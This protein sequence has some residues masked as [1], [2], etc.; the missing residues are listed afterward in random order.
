[1]KRVLPIWSVA[2]VAAI[3]ACGAT[4][5]GMRF[6]LTPAPPTQ[7]T[8]PTRPSTP[9]VGVV[10]MISDASASLELAKD[11]NT[12]VLALVHDLQ[13]HHTRVEEL[14]KRLALDIA[15]S[16]EAGAIDEKGLRS[17][18]EA[19]GRARAEVA[20]VD[21]KGLEELH[22]ILT[23]G[24]RK[25]FATALSAMA[26]KLP[27]DDP[28]RRYS[29]WRSDLE[30]SVDQK[31]KIEG[32]LDTDGSLV[33]SANAEQEAWRRRLRATANDFTGDAYSAAAYSDPDVVATT[34][35]RVR[36][37]AAFLNAVVPYLSPDQRKLAAANLRAEVG[38]R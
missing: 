2:V 33:A 8:T 16:V 25:Q 28:H 4:G 7:D 22:Q 36:R 12:R 38:V 30:I 17:D 11:Q 10:S 9:E 13:D 14:K 24:Q 35:E 32:K 21:A 23:S 31:D 37:L 18:A 26:D 27:N 6:D 5:G 19:L 15:A 1:M 29:N 20:P 34:I 3:A